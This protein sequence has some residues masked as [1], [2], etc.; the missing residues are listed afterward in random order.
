VIQGTQYCSFGNLPSNK[1][2]FFKI[3]PYT[4]SG[5]LI[6]YKNDGTAPGASATTPNTVIIDSVHFTN[7]TFG[8]WTA[9]SVVGAQVWA[10][11][12]IHGVNQTPC[13]KM[14]G[15]ATISNENEDWFI[16]KSMN[17]NLYNNENLTFMSA[18]KYTGPALQCLI[19]N[20][21]DGVGN[22]GDF[23][24][25][26]LTA[27]WSTGN[28][29][30]APSGNINVSGI[31]GTNVHIAFKYTSTATESST[32]EL[33]DIIVTGDVIIGVSENEITTGFSV[34]P[35]PA[36][37]KCVI[38]FAD[39]NRKQV[40]LINMMGQSVRDIQTSEKNY[41]LDLNELSAGLYFIKVSAG[42]STKTQKLII[43]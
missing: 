2:Y 32:W 6:N 42:N 18:Y 34:N 4:N 12:S 8:N 28:W 30:W 23:T 40:S 9:K 10:V 27:T 24:W 25:L 5:N 31:S 37:E 43:R 33:D 35:N 39:D 38:R 1:L 15:Y 16:S 14:S 41:T 11:D 21:Y 26:P 22:P 17:F 19:S 13:T 36:S 3:Y 7:Y 29:V 20:D